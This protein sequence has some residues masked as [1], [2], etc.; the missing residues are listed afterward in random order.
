M[1]QLK[2]R[3]AIATCSSSVQSHIC[4]ER[5]RADERA[6][7]KWS[8][9]CEQLLYKEGT[10]RGLTESIGQAQRA[11]HDRLCPNLV[12]CSMRQHTYDGQNDTGLLRL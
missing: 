6:E 1:I 8:A 4:Q 7:S 11:G 5:K 12:L 2:A 9:G 10:P 3:L